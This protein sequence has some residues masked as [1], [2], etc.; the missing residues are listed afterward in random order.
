MG[1]GERWGG[2]GAYSNKYGTL[3]CV[4]LAIVSPYCN[5]VIKTSLS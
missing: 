4:K 2:V 5:Y 1:V 3:Y